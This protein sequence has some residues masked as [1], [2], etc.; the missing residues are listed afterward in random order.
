MGA[1]YLL[2]QQS[3]ISNKQFNKM[4]KL[5]IIALAMVTCCLAAPQAPETANA[6]VPAANATAPAAPS[7]RKKRQAPA[8]APSANATDPAAAAAPAAPAAAPAARRKRQAP[9]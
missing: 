7:A 6:T 2:H 3:N 4:A 1:F 5:L 9:A 8:A